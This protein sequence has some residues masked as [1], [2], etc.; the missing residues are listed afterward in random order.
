MEK[1]NAKIIRLRDASRQYE[2]SQGYNKIYIL[3]WIGTI[4]SDES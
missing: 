4:L 1:D 2:Y 3:E